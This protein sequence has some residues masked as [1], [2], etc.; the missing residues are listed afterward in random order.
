MS[1]I[2]HEG[3]NL[4]FF[5]SMKKYIN[6]SGNISI[7]D[8]LGFG[9]PDIIHD[10]QAKVNSIYPN[11][12]ETSVALTKSQNKMVKLTAKARNSSLI[13]QDP[14]ICQAIEIK[15]TGVNLSSEATLALTI[16]YESSKKSS[17]A[18]CKRFKHA[19][20]D[21]EYAKNLKYN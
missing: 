18:L 11:I 12:F 4:D 15:E 17:D 9:N 7:P 2:I 3:T 14:I 1:Q 8:I 13:S 16:D 6:W 21:L 19:K 20:S 5:V 10:L